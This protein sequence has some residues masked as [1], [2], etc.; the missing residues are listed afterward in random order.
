MLSKFSLHSDPDEL[1]Q[2]QSSL[3]THPKYLFLRQAI[4]IEL[5]RLF[6]RDFNEEQF[7]EAL[8]MFVKATDTFS[9][10]PIIVS[11]KLLSGE[12]QQ[13]PAVD[14][15]LIT[16]ALDTCQEGEVEET[17]AKLTNFPSS[18]YS[19][20]MAKPVAFEMV[21]QAG[22]LSALYVMRRNRG[23]GLVESSS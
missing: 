22:I 1:L 16:F 4:R 20:T 19:D 15:E 8:T 6:P 14:A 10:P 5:D 17:R 23:K 9:A 21:S 3:P 11:E 12:D 2:I 13:A 18:C 7:A